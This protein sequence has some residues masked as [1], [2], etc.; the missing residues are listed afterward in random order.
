MPASGPCRPRVALLREVSARWGDALREHDDGPLDRERARA[1]QRAYAAA[2]L[3]AGVRVVMLP[4][5][6]HPDGCFTEDAAVVL[7]RH[8]LVTRPGAPSRRGEVG[9]VAGALAALGCV[10]HRMAAPATLEG[11]DVLRIGAR[12]LV[13][14]SRR[15]NE[16]G[17]A[18]LARVAARE[19]LRV[20]AVAI[21]DQMHL[22]GAVTLAA[23]G[24]AVV[25]PRLLDPA[26]LADRGL[27]VI[28]ADEHVGANVLALGQ[29]QVLVPA[30]APRTAAALRRRGLH[31]LEVPGDE[32]HRAD[33]RLTCLSLR[34][35]PPGGWC[36]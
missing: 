19:G 16:A 28:E 12:L 22:K 2:L 32:I 8:A 7:G 3:D 34:L 30:E 4:A 24:L 25:D 11:G 17:V 13:G 10:V 15:T 18:A 6:P 5:G 23:A 14:L 21:G 29:A 20:E 9:S 31:T 35:P 26:V 1:Q 33:G 27:A 36:A